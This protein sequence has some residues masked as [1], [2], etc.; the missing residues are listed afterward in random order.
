MVGKDA[1]PTKLQKTR[2][3]SEPIGE[4]S[5]LNKRFFASQSFAQN[6]EIVVMSKKNNKCRRFRAF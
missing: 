3:N 1:H 4:E 2:R 5:H 6:D